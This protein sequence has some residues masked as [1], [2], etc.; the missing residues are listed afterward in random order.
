MSTLSAFITELRERRL[1][2]V[3][4]VLLIGIVAVP[5]VLAKTPPPTPAPVRSASG[6]P[7]AGNPAVPSVSLGATPAA[8]PPR[9]G[10]RNPFTPA[11]GTGAQAPASPASSAGSSPATSASSGQGTGTG[12]ASAGTGT[13][14]ASAGTGTGA[15]SAGTGTSTPSSGTT[16]AGTGSTGSSGGT[17]TGSG[18]QPSDTPA[19]PDGKP[20]KPGPAQLSATQAYRVA[21]AISKAG[22]G[23]AT[24]DSLERLSIL[25]S[26]QQPLLVELGVSQGGRRV[27]FA[28][29]S[30]AVITGPGGCTPGPI[31]CQILSLA[32]GQT[33]TLS[34]SNGTVSNL[35]FAV[36]A[37]KATG[38]RSRSA[39]EQARR[40][41]SAAGHE[42]LTSSTLSALTLFEYDPTVG[43][44]V[45]LRN[46]KVGRR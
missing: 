7:V 22:S 44:I 11:P 2:P 23:L 40:M 43:A 3:A 39:A 24:V 6:L 5:L 30:G 4:V 13:S 25:P 35:L 34:S 29:Q 26:P 41:A 42:L 31:D 33:E 9:G 16:S 36:T 18:T 17:G 15:A 45:D 12:A 1:W 27:L 21:L 28:V 8:T 10:A 19:A 20:S 46:L 38:Y 32:P 37:I 14:A